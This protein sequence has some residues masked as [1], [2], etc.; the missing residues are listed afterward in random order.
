MTIKLKLREDMLESDAVFL[1]ADGYV[2]ADREDFD[3][4]N[5]GLYPGDLMINVHRDTGELLLVVLDLVS[6]TLNDAVVSLRKHPLPW[7]FSLPELNI[8]K[9]PLADILEKV[10]RKYRKIIMECKENR[11]HIR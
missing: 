2:S 4:Y 6:D 3:S 7:T 8:K 9:K 10:Y 11:N 1:E 5:A